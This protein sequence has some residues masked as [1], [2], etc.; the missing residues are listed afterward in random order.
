VGKWCHLDPEVYCDTRKKSFCVNGG[1]CPTGDS[2][3]D[4]SCNCMDDFIGKH[5]EYHKGET[6]AL[7]E[8]N[9][10]EVTS[11]GSSVG[12]EGNDNGH[13]GGQDCPL[14]CR[15]GSTCKKDATNIYLCVCPEGF[16][17][18]HCEKV[19]AVE[20]PCGPYG[21]VCHHGSTCMRTIQGEYAC[22]CTSKDLT[23]SMTTKRDFAG[24]WCNYEA[25]SYCDTD[26]NFFC[27]NNG[28]CINGGANGGG[29]FSCSC[30]ATQ[31]TGD[32][33]EKSI[34]DTTPE[35]SFYENCTLVCNNGG[36]CQKGAK[37]TTTLH[38][39]SDGKTASSSETFEHCVCPRGFTGLACEQK[40]EEC[41]RG[42]HYC[43]HGSSCTYDDKTMDGWS[44]DCPNAS[45]SQEELFAG[46]HC[47]HHATSIC[48]VEDTGDRFPIYDPTNSI[49]FCV[50]DGLCNVNVENGEQ[51]P[52]CTC[53]PGYSGRHC[54]LLGTFQNDMGS[55]PNGT[56]QKNA[57]AILVICLVLGI[58][59]FFIVAIVVLRW[60][61]LQV[62][63]RQF[64]EDK[65]T[66]LHRHEPG[67]IQSEVMEEV[68]FSDDFDDEDLEDVELL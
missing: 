55:N 1:T 67:M 56:D 20:S 64:S 63:E 15:N 46:N 22:D 31:W 68:N 44:C 23:D 45:T 3:N 2:G 6:S 7:L 9:G 40:Y 8:G 21:D 65:I 11:G 5:C 14:E 27:V 10:G 48:T 59:F 52:G 41:G 47:Q 19:T 38:Q 43:L 62:Q 50:N 36:K 16:E 26:Q 61:R 39:N 24:R 57:A 12:G 53:P 33:C 18:L 4:S 17:G 42:E 13:N 32:Q 30:D 28:S 49:A 37:K 25:T 54:E 51:V 58:L 34:A 29:K 66:D 35:D 60:R